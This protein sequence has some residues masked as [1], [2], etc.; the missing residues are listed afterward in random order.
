MAKKLLFLVVCGPLL[1]SLTSTK[2]SANCDFTN[3]DST[4][5]SIN[6]GG[7][8]ITT[9][10][11]SHLLGEDEA[12]NKILEAA[13]TTEE[14]RD[15]LLEYLARPE[16]AEKVLSEQSESTSLIQAAR[17]GSVDWIG[18]EASPEEIARG[19]SFEELIAS[20]SG[21]RQSFSEILNQEQLDQIMHLYFPAHIIARAKDPEAFR[22]IRPVG[23]DDDAQKALGYELLARIENTKPEMID[24][25][26]AGQLS[27]EDALAFLSYQ[28][29]AVERFSPFTEDE[30]NSYMS[31]FE[32]E[33]VREI[34]TQNLNSINGFLATADE[35]SL[36]AARRAIAE[37]GNGLIIFGSAHGPLIDQELRRLC[38]QSGQV[39]ASDVGPAAPV[40]E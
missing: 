29:T 1:T 27:Q 40:E 16:I 15:G 14:M 32:N 2:V 17:N 19:S 3:L 18:I 22:S 7:S 25:I 20:Y 6:V 4:H 39:P 12:I 11:S 13:T 28:W 33:R 36:T 31:S 24:L 34:F 35:R 23:L 38:L 9:Y 21:L 26:L 10:Y 30:I 8:T 37:S 5:R